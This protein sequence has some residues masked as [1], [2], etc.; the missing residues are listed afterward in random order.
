M[1]LNPQTWFTIVVAAWL[2]VLL[3]NRRATERTK[4]TTGEHL[5]QVGKFADRPDYALWDTHDRL[6]L[7]EAAYLWAERRPP[8]ALREPAD[9]RATEVYRMLSGA[10]EAGKV[11]AGD[12]RAPVIIGASAGRRGIAMQGGIRPD[13]DVTRESL[14]EFAKTTGQRPKFLFPSAR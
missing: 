12:W 4:L 10:I 1:A 6:K 11:D 9:G 13:L 3:A 2:Y 7:V 5:A 8:N 14:V